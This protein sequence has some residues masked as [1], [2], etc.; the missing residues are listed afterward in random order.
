[1]TSHSLVE[2]L[3]P[4]VFRRSG[5]IL[6]R[7]SNYP[8]FS[9]PWFWRRSALFVLV[10]I[11]FTSVGSSNVGLLSG[12]ATLTIGYAWRAFLA[13]LIVVTLGP[14]IGTI[15]RHAR[16]KVRLER[17]ILPIVIALSI[18]L[19]VI[20]LR[21][22]GAYFDSEVTPT[23]RAQV[24]LSEQVKKIGARDG[25]R[26]ANFVLLAAFVSAVGGGFALVA[27]FTETRRL[28]EYR[29][30]QELLGL[31]EARNNADR[32]L[33]VLQA[34]V[35]P[36]FLYNTLASVRSLVSTDAPRAVA[37]IDALVDHLR[38]TLPKMRERDDARATLAEQV[39]IC[40]S[41]LEVIRVRMGTRFR[42]S[43][44]LQENCGSLFFPPLMLI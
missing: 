16:L 38:A 24:Q 27:Y 23:M 18:A 22:F 41:Y 21:W 4:E 29:Q 39:E 32:K 31:R 17:W 42:Y 34:Q 40:R 37:T 36:H 11:A 2:R 9:W 44:Q 13:L 15:V 8:V 1:M 5:S 6:T 25:V 7:Y 30:Q 19:G 28:R 43:I 14:A 35:E 12:S 26:A 33:S 3:P 10:P 20:S